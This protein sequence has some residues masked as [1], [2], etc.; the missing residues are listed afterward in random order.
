MAEPEEEDD[1]EYIDDDED[2]ESLVDDYFKDIYSDL[3][4]RG[5]P[6]DRQPTTLQVLSHIMESVDESRLRVWMEAYAMCEG[7]AERKAERK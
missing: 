6:E 1:V 3:S 2:F 5:V 7:K 4:D